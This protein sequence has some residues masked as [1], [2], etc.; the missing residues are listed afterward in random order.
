M[1]ILKKK[2]S[3]ASLANGAPPGSLVEISDTGYMN[4]DLFIKWLE[5]F[6]FY[7]KPNINNKVLLML[8][9]HTTH[10]KN[11]K[12]ISMVRENGVLILQMPSQPP[13][14]YNV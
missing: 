7:V 9:G 8:D 4:T 3:H 11:L 13:F 2:R 5:L 6:I 14:G 10:S 12:A 1:I